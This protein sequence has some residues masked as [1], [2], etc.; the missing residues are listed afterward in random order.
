MNSVSWHPTKLLLAYA[1]DDK[2]RTGRDE[3]SLRV[4]GFPPA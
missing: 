2:D 3:G 1:G 4:F